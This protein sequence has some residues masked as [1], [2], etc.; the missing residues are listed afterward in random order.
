MKEVLSILFGAGF[1]AG[2]S[3][4]I[5]TVLLRSLRI[6]LYRTEATVFAF[7]VGSGV[8]SLIVTLL[9]IVQV[10]RKGVFLWGG[11]AAIA[12]ALWRARANRIVRRTL[13][14]IRLDWLV[15]CILVFAALFVY[16]LINAMAPEV[17]PDGSG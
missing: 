15:P 8:L 2:V 17:S 1:T 11:V 6:R 12:I 16:Y 10:G 13:P 7:I 5:G 4:A 14:A 9:C 3:L